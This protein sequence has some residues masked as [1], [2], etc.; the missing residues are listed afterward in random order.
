MDFEWDAAKAAANQRKHGIG[1]DEASSVFYD[2]DELS[3]K[4][5]R[6]SENEERWVTIGISSRLR[7]LVVVSTERFEKTVR[8]IGARKANRSEVKLYEEA[9]KRSS[10]GG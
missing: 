7:T 10:R 6:H 3:R 9:R 5:Q 8:I 2:P 1:F 4:D